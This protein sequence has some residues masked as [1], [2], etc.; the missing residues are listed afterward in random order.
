MLT[1]LGR[2]KEELTENFSKNLENIAKYPSQLKKS[3]TNIKK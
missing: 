1:I 3:I 2:R